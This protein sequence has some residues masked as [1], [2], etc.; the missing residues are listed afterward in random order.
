M[1]L[2][3]LSRY[4]SYSLKTLQTLAVF[5]ASLGCVILLVTVYIYQISIIVSFS[6]C[7]FEGLCFARVVLRDSLLLKILPMACSHIS[8]PSMFNSPEVDVDALSLRQVCVLPQAG[9]G[10]TRFDVDGGMRPRF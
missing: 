7:S 4:P 1:L 8:D 2:F 5:L 10:G 9:R 3:L 6:S